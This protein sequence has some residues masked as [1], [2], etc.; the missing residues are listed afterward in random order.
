MRVLI[1]SRIGRT[2]SM[3]TGGVVELP[4]FVAFAGED[5]AGVAAAHG[6]DHVAVAGGVVVEE[7]GLLAGDVDADLGHRLD[8]DRV[9]P[10]SGFGSCGA[11][12]NPVAGEVA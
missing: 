12:L 11:D 4:V 5:R 9:D 6:D 2:A 3:L 8:G 1:W 7:F 10:V